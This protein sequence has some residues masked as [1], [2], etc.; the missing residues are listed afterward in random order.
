MRAVDLRSGVQ[1]IVGERGSG[2]PLGAPNKDF[3]GPPV[4][5]LE[6]ERSDL[7]VAKTRRGEQEQERSVP[8]T[9]GGRHLDRANGAQNIFPSKARRQVR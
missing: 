1:D 2:L 6:L 5:I 7:F 3:P 8:N 4:D 9:D